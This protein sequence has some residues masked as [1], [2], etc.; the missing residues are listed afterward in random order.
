[1]FGWLPFSSP[2]RR[3]LRAGR[4]M[5][6]VPAGWAK[7]P[8]GGRAFVPGFWL[9]EAPIDNRTY[10]AFQKATGAP[11]PP[12]MRRVGW[13]DP[14]QPI[15]GLT[16]AEARALCRWL[17]LRLPT[18]AE[19]ARAHGPRPYP[20]G[21]AAPTSKL[22]V[23]GQPPNTPPCPAG[24]PDGRGPFGHLDLVGNVW[25]RVAEGVAVG[26][27]RGSPALGRDLVLPLGPDEVSGGVGLRC[28]W[29]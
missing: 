9:D 19:W 17:G 11:G 5:L 8:G 23:F 24:R 20:W 13:D 1:V 4:V 21:V 29:R 7:V 15:V 2:P 16:A 26:G 18:L 6:R 25:E 12:W 28:A 14:D 10:R 27:F 3:A 22:A